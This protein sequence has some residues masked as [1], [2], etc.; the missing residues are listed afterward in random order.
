MLY[1]SGNPAGAWLTDLEAEQQ[2]NTSSM[3]H[4]GVPRL[5]DVELIHVTSRPESTKGCI[6]PL[7]CLTSQ[8]QRAKGCTI[9][10]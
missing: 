1:L 9:R 4:T 10:E 8:P 7:F 5:N 2:M 3:P 6:S